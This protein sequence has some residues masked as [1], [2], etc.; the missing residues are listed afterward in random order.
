MPPELTQAEIQLDNAQILVTAGSGAPGTDGANGGAGG[1][2]GLS[3]GYAKEGTLDKDLQCLK[4]TAGGDGGAGGGG[5]AGAGGIAGKAITY[6]MTCNKKVTDNCNEATS[7]Q[8]CFIAGDRKTF[9]NCGY[10]LPVKLIYYSNDSAF[11]QATPGKDRA[12]AT[13]QKADN[14]GVKANTEFGADGPSA[15][16]ETYITSY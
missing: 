8:P 4:A 9:A 11:G 16:I 2:A 6:L 7:S 13:E 5:G 10:E 15:F 1:T 14:L 12:D 3:A